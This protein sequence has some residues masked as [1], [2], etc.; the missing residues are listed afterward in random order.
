MISI[1]KLSLI[2]LSEK[3]GYRLIGPNGS[4]C[5]N[6]RWKPSALLVRCEKDLFK[7][8]KEP[9]Q[10]E[11]E[12]VEEN[13]NKKKLKLFRGFSPNNVQTS[14]DLALWSNENNT[15]RISKTKLRRLKK[16]KLKWLQSLKNST[17]PEE[18]KLKYEKKYLKLKRRNKLGGGDN[19]GKRNKTLSKGMKRKRFNKIKQEQIN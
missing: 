13:D 4:T 16:H 8:A 19:K 14:Q 12:E 10:Y 5:I 9:Y 15:T 3:K 7:V 6:G 18:F 11:M 2:K 17:D 1:F